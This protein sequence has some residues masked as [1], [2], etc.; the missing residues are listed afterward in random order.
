MSYFEDVEKNPGVLLTITFEEFGGEGRPG[1]VI[2]G[3]KTVELAF[4]LIYS[5][6]SSILVVVSVIVSIY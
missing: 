1:V 3:R 4:P 2:I 5:T 6:V